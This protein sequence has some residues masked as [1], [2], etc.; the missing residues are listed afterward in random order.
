MSKAIWDRLAALG[1]VLF[2]F[3][4][5]VGMLL[6]GSPP[7]VNDPSDDVVSFFGDN[8]GQVLM[9]TLFIGLGVLA[10][11]WFVAS[12]VE[13][14]RRADEDRLATTAL[15]GFV[16]TFAV[17]TVSALTRASLA[18]SVA[19]ILQPDET[20]A[21][22]HVSLVMDAMSS[23]M[24]AAFAI[25]VGVAS[26]RS[27]VLP[28]WWGWVSGLMGVLSILGATAWSR[29]GFWSP[30]GGLIWILNISFVVYIAGT[31]VLHFREVSRP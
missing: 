29:D 10:M 2:V 23:L 16:L 28:R 6:P 11:V 24:F 13:A 30:T 12:L 19:G 27:G 14:M 31:S 3:F 15:I 8:R 21:L 25:A 5:I 1:G 22:F 26:L 20:R 9:G 17:G 4:F 7:T 18:Y